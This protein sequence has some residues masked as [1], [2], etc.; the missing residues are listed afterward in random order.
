MGI[1]SVLE[2]GETV[3]SGRKSSTITFDATQEQKRQLL[4][5]IDTQ[6]HAVEGIKHQVVEALLGTSQGVR[7]HFAKEAQR[8]EQWIGRVDALVD[9]SHPLT[10]SSNLLD[11]SRQAKEFEKVSN[12]GSTLQARLL[13]AFVEQAGQLRAEG[14]RDI[15]NVESLLSRGTGLISS[16]F[17]PEEIAR[18][19]GLVRRLHDDLQEDR[20][21]VVS[22]TATSLEQDLSAKLQMSEA[23]ESKYQHR[24]YVLKALRQVCA[25]MG[26]DEI[27]PPQPERSDDRKSR[28]KL[29]VDTIN[30][31]QVTFYLSLESIEADSCISQSHCFEEFGELSKQLTETFGILTKFK[32]VNAEVA[33]RLARKGE[34]EEPQGTSDKTE[35]GFQ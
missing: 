4:G 27:G 7:E 3:M 29:T 13:D 24:L 28:I 6:R 14:A 18:A 15:F 11:I 32:I 10:L 30:R 25:E 31:G 35:V 16:W 23:N 19:H 33:P 20:L 5:Q 21:D 26:F 1:Q 2:K 9:I 12:E 8:A 34:L 17:G 22:R